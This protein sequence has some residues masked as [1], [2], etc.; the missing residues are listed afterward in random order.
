MT[1]LI[2]Q[3]VGNYQLTELL[4]QGG[5]AEVYLADHLHLKTRAAI[6]ILF[7]KLTLEDQETFLRE[8]QTLA[9]LRHPHILR[10]LDFG[11][12][13][14]LPFLVMD[15]APGGTLR[16]R[17][18]KRSQVPLPTVIAYV[19]QIASA[20]VY[21]HDH[22]LIHRDVKPENMLIGAD[23]TILLA[24]F[25]TVTTAHSISS[26]KTIDQAGTVYYMAPEQIQGKPLP[27]SDQYALAVVIYEWL[28]GERPF[29]GESMIEI[30]MK[31]LTQAPPPIRQ[32]LPTF[33][34]RIEQI[35]AR[36]LAKD[37]QQ[38]YPSIR[39]FADAFLFPL[40]SPLPDDKS[41]LI[42]QNGV[43]DE[44]ERR[45]ALPIAPVSAALT[46]R[47]NK[48]Y[49][50]VQEFCGFTSR[51]EHIAWS[52]DSHTIASVGQG[53]KFFTLWNTENGEIVRQ[54]HFASLRPALRQNPTLQGLRSGPLVWSSTAMVIAVG[55]SMTYWG[56]AETYEDEKTASF[57]EIWDAS[58]GDDPL[59]ILKVPH[60]DKADKLYDL[61]ITDLAWPLDSQQIISVD[62]RRYNNSIIP[63]EGRVYLWQKKSTESVF[64][65]PSLLY[66]HKPGPLFAI[67]SSPDGE[68]IAYGG[69]GSVLFLHSIKKGIQES[70][71]KAKQYSSVVKISWSPDSTH[72]AYSLNNN[73][74]TVL[75][76]KTKKIVS[77][78]HMWDAHVTT[79][80]VWS[81]NGKYIASAGTDSH[82][83]FIFDPYSNSDP[84][85]TY[86]PDNQNSKVQTL[87]W[88]PDGSRIAVG[89]G[90]TVG[91][92]ELDNYTIRVYEAPQ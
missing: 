10:V 41:S 45:A 52:A 9:K 39:T 50:I 26:I 60:D 79:A 43:F 3:Q 33:P 36:A 65:P 19:E 7:G 24:D 76:V 44:K 90:W 16:D 31:H 86:L 35:L 25:G 40:T 88:S 22:K 23:G 2:G 71:G 81:P 63:K 49:K 20:L 46:V 75:D 30:A 69:E 55:I 15:Y 13:H 85:Y 58:S 5:F 29:T 11:F 38:R 17:H 64:S 54:C 42:R 66:T 62:Q 6:K 1:Y 70:I 67:A 84:L 61:E 73:E 37:P 91:Y 77:K 68:Y 47:K 92:D 78:H 34:P 14:A 8:A 32:K 83:F 53:N 21:T 4:G 82:H 27:A 28:C 59:Y 89:G 72:V 57:V 87:A 51:V 12:T 56:W 80:L 48:A 18:P 74:I